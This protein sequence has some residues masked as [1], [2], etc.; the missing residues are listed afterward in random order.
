MV[1]AAVLLA[2]CSESENLA[3]AVS[4]GD[5]VVRL[6]LD[7]DGMGWTEK[8][9]NITRAGETLSGLRATTGDLPSGYDHGFG[10][11]VYATNTSTSTT[12]AMMANRQV[13]WDIASARWNYGY[14]AY[15]PK[16]S[17]G[18][19]LKAYAYA[20]YN[21][22]F[23]VTEAGKLSFTAADGQSAVDL[24]YAADDDINRSTGETE[25]TFKHALAKLTLGTIANTS[26]ARDMLV[27]DIIVKGNFYTGGDLDLGTGEWTNKTPVSPTEQ[28]INII[29]ESKGELIC[30]PAGAQNVVRSTKAEIDYVLGRVNLISKDAPSP[31]IIPGPTASIT[32]QYYEQP[33]LMSPNDAMFSC[34]TGPGDGQTRTDDDI[35]ES[36]TAD[37]DKS[38]QYENNVGREIGG[39]ATVMGSAKVNCNVYADWTG[40]DKLI[41]VGTKDLGLRIL[42]NRLAPTLL[43]AGETSAATVNTVA[44]EHSFPLPISG[45]LADNVPTVSISPG[46]SFVVDPTLKSEG[47]AT[48]YA[49]LPENTTGATKTYTVTV[50]GKTSAGVDFTTTVTIN[51]A[52]KNDGF[53]YSGSNDKNG[54]LLV[55]VWAVIGDDGYVVVD[56]TN[57][58]TK[59][60]V[61]PVDLKT[62]EGFLHV[63]AIKVH[64]NSVSGT[65]SKLLL[66]RNG[67]TKNTITHE[68]LTTEEGVDK[69]LNLRMG[70]NFEVIIEE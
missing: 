68:G 59:D 5:D 8:T 49:S 1:M 48:I 65:V 14:D 9:A 16:T 13:T 18:E 57:L 52:Y 67:A 56:L 4:A 44:T 63:N 10:L 39:Y 21:S 33:G 60:G 3:G 38:Y 62:R 47:K 64:P 35:I 50:T 66:L 30:V 54:G 41:I 55:E 53:Y 23:S 70:K 25:L 31:M 36:G 61:G 12:T 6:T 42:L 28:T 37:S 19:N 29:E 58:T 26:S 45:F 2:G 46:R 15:W 20:P 34:W 24:L 7:T 22:S 51:Q 17:T 69:T 40:Y 27:S 32:Y 43:V 11:Y